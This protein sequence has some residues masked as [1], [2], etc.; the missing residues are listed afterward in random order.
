VPRGIRLDERYGDFSTVIG[1][2]MK[3]V[4]FALLTGLGVFALVWWR[5]TMD[6]IKVWHGLPATFTPPDS[7]GKPVPF[8]HRHERYMNV[9]EVMVTLA[10]ASL[11][12]VPSSRLSLYSHA[13]AFALILLGLCVL[14]SVGFMA[15]MT[16]FYERF[17]YDDQ[18][19]RLGNMDCCMALVLVRCFVS[20]LRISFLPGVSQMPSSTQFLFLG[21]LRHSPLISSCLNE[22]HLQPEL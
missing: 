5:V 17:L 9:A 10:S 3:T 15:L 14:Y 6:A 2:A 21:T 18:T 22:R 1:A 19:T 12:F 20:L 13:C 16:Y 4:I 7:L 11:V 8:E